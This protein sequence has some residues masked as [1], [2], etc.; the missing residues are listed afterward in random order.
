[1]Q[2]ELQHARAERIAL[3]QPRREAFETYRRENLDSVRKASIL[4]F[5]IQ[6]VLP[7]ILLLMLSG[8]SPKLAQK[9]GDYRIDEPVSAGRT[10]DAS[11]VTDSTDLA[12]EFEATYTEVDGKTASSSRESDAD[13]L[14][15][16]GA[17]LEASGWTLAEADVE[18]AVATDKRKFAN[19]LFYT[20]E[21]ELEVIIIGR[22]YV[23]VLIHPFRHYF[24][25]ARGRIPYLKS[26]MARAVFESLDEEFTAQ[27]FTFIGNAG[28]RNAA[29]QKGEG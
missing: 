16:V 24:W 15:R 12:L 5:R 22:K 1:M 29:Y 4:L 6:S 21:A 19:W 28:M 10:A 27:G 20:V 14:K 13:V 9:Y 7:A 11:P 25:G 17:A 26:G 8:C 23:R 3:N 2:N 18:Y